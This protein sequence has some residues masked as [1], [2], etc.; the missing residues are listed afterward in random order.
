MVLLLSPY[1]SMDWSS[2]IPSAPLDG[3]HQSSLSHYCCKLSLHTG[4]RN[5]WHLKSR[6][7]LLINVKLCL[8]HLP[9]LGVRRSSSVV[10]RPLA[11]HIVIF[12]S[13]TPQ[14]NEL[15]HIRNHLWKVL[16]KECPFRP[17]PLS[18]RVIIVSVWSI[19]K[20]VLL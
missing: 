19:F 14:P 11:F 5:T 2:Q 13:E 8:W 7:K 10:C 6:E 1:S 18:N 3:G 9:S 12:F 17:D 20:N 16:Y 15:K 4:R